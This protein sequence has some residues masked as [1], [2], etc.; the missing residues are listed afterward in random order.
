MKLRQILSWAL[1][2][3][4]ILLMAG[5]LLWDSRRAADPSAVTTVSF[6]TMSTIAT[7]QF[8]GSGRKVDRAAAD[9][10]AQ[11]TSVEKL[12]NIFDPASELSR[13]NASAAD[14][15]FRCSGEL[16]E[17]LTLSRKYH[18]LSDGAFDPTIR[19]LMNLWGFH[20][21]RKTVPSQAE[22][23]SAL[24]LCGLDKVVFDDAAKTVFF[25]QKGMSVDLGGI[26]KGWAVDRA[27]AAAVQ[28]GI[29]RGTIDLG[30]NIR[31][32]AN[33]RPYTIGIRDPRDGSKLLRKFTLNGESIATSGS[34]ERFS[35]ID[36]KR[37]SHIMNPKTGR[38]VPAEMLSAT[39]IAPTAVESDAFSTSVFINGSGFAEKAHLRFLTVTEKE[40][41]DR[42]EVR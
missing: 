41:T 32:I 29:R 22:I 14:R 42:T 26:A 34:Y 20:G 15:P 13:L 3:S 39:V 16:W 37:Y 28:A 24:R 36:G 21:K 4:G 17:I 18:V 30:G 31:T 25:P 23:D 7:F 5:T 6:G 38:P 33:D 27:A 2:G 8:S 9:A 40:T 12:C 35:V 11:I 10:R 1:I 19:P